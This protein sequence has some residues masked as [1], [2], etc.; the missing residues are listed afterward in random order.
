MG[1]NM[2]F[3]KRHFEWLQFHLQI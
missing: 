1:R 3:Q 2:V